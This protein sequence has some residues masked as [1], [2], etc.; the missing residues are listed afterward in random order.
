MA[1][2]SAQITWRIKNLQDSWRQRNA[3]FEIAYNLREMKDTKKKAGELSIAMNDGRVFL[4]LAIHMLSHKPPI[5]RVPILGRSD[6][7]QSAAGGTEVFLHGVQRQI[8]AGRFAMGLSPWQRDM[9][10]FLAS[11]GWWADMNVVLPCKD[12]TPDFIAEV[13]DPA[14]VFPQQG[15]NRLEQVAHVYDAT[16][17]EVQ[18]KARMFNWEGNFSGDSSLTVS[19]QNYY[20][21]EEDIVWN[22]L[23]VEHVTTARK[24][25]PDARIMAIA[26][27]A[28]EELK[29]IPI[30]TGPV[31][32]WAVRNSRPGDKPKSQTRYGESILAAGAPIYDMKNTWA[33]IALRKAQES[34]EPNV[35]LRSNNGRWTVSEDDLRSGV[36]IPVARD[37]NIE[38]RVKPGLTAEVASVVMP[39][40]DA[41]IQRSGASDLLLGNINP[42]DLAGAGYAL[43]LTEPRILSKILPYAKAL[44]EIGSTRDTEF[45][46]AFRDGD[47]KPIQLVSRNDEARDIRRIYF[48][49]WKS[50]DLPKSSLVN[51]EVQVSM[52]DQLQMKIAI[53][54]QAI[55]QGDILDLD[56]AL[57]SVL[58]V[59]DVARV[60][61]GIEEGKLMRDPAVAVVNS[62][63]HLE[64]YAESLRANA[65]EWRQRG[66]DRS[67]ARA[68]RAAVRIEQVI[69]LRIQS[70]GGSAN[71]QTDTNGLPPE[72]FGTQQ[73]RELAG[74][75]G[76]GQGIP[77]GGV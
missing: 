39:M 40:L 50:G 8:D 65:E 37:Q 25:T 5:I 33:T 48:Q 76:P 55:P 62:I 4:D 66:E 29:R 7:E 35:L 69:E 16:L 20:W 9:A 54:R 17:G 56:T 26:P 42:N 41:A 11:T 47:Y 3:A 15:F 72:A 21:M 73:G 38:D 13:L 57:E 75:L 22:A 32:G 36:G 51:W 12:G 43:S 61:R 53:A 71:Q 64:E 45:L 10:D 49:E 6:P 63:T 28:R 19:V 59:D 1:M 70:L 60:K 18:T 44:E 14:E 68:E 52:P 34:V 67:A 2:D 58:K 74:A 27:I 30:R 77:G 24:N 46:E 31:G 23:I